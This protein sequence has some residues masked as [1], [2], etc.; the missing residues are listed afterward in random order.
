MRKHLVSIQRQSSTQ[1]A[2]GQPANTWTE[3][4]TWWASINPVSGREYFNASGE[5]AEVTHK[6]EGRYGPTI[7]PRDRI[8]HGSRVF[9]VKS[10]LNLEE[11]NHWLQL[12][13]TEHVN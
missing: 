2:T 11:C 8:V 12:M 9:N 10:V 7:A 1:G 3:T 13:A 4:A 5:R 6:I